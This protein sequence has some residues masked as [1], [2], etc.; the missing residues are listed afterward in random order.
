M[1]RAIALAARLDFEIDPPVAEA[2][3]LH[4]HEIA[5]SSPARLLEEYYKILRGGYAE[6]TFRSLLTA[7]LLEPVTPEL[8]KGAGD[9]W[10]RSLAALDAYRRQFPVLPETVSN[11]V[12]LGTLLTA[13]GFPAQSARHHADEESP[14]LGSLP[15]ARRDVERLRQMIS[16]Q[17]RLRDRGANPRA[18]ES[19]VGR[20]IFRDALS[21]LEVHGHAPEMA[22]HWKNVAEQAS[23][24]SIE[25]GNEA[26]PPAARRRRRRRRRRYRP[27]QQS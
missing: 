23:G 4:R 26:Q 18:Q 14:R 3:R 22:A 15:I 2:I 8:H 17:R 25:P 9:A 13:L 24:H 7:G 12:L 6:R 27:T 21:W 1:L 5:R 11:A 20:T 16:F 10:W 19:L